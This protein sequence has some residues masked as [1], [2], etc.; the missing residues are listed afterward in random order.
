MELKPHP[1]QKLHLQGVQLLRADPCNLSPTPVQ[2]A[3][4]VEKLGCHHGR[5]DEHALE[6]LRGQ[7]CF[8]VSILE[9]LQV[10][11]G[12]DE[13]GRA[14]L[15]VLCYAIHVLGRRDRG[16][17]ADKG[18]K[19]TTFSPS[20]VA[21]H[22]GLKN[23]SAHTDQV[24]LDCVIPQY[25]FSLIVQQAKSVVFVDHGFNRLLAIALSCVFLST[26][27]GFSVKSL[28]SLADRHPFHQH[29]GHDEAGRAAL[30]VPCDSLH[31]LCW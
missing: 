14:A 10:Y 17:P 30:A 31:I 26:K 25:R 1:E 24:L 19:V 9:S 22:C 23:L 13:A 8:R 15:A 6:R 20:I 2:A 27:H 4:I 3:F 18:F 21:V 12:H 7:V 5:D 28:H 11:A 16:C 29:T